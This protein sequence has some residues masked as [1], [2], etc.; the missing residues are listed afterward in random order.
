MIYLD[1]SALIKN[2]SQEPGTNAV[3]GIMAG[4]HRCGISK[5]GFAEVCAAFGRKN[6][7]KPGD[8]RTHLRAF[9]NF[10]E[11][12]KL[13]TVVEVGD[14]LLPVI[15]NLTERYP[16]RGGDA[17]HLAS[18]LW[19]WRALQD[20]VTFVSADI[21]LSKAAHEERLKVINPET[22]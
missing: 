21:H 5:I 18:A 4:S 7:E 10:M 1:S 20:E 22:T 8:R 17:I 15:R 13:F 14:D 6:R 9:Q 12:W 3:R 16:L 11:D 19:L 2:Y